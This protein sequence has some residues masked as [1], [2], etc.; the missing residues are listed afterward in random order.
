MGLRVVGAGLGRTGTLSLKL[1]LERLLGGPCYHMFEVMA[2]PEHV[3]LWRRAYEGDPPLWDAIF[4]DYVACVDWPAAPWWREL[5][6][7]YGDAVVLLSERDSDE[8]WYRSASRTIFELMERLDP[9]TPFDGWRAMATRM[10]EAF[11]PDLADERATRRAYLDHNAAVR[12][13]VAPGRLVEWRPA[14][15]WGPL[16]AG[17]GLAVPDEPFPHTNTTEEFRARTGWS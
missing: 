3:D 16:C 4:G 2:H 10:F 1:A 9:A 14:D 5:S 8:Q 17:L 12:A 15:G 7:E 13:G 6:T 11:T